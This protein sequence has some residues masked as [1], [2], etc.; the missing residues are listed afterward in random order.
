MLVSAARALRR[1]LTPRSLIFGISRFPALSYRS[2][3][4]SPN[5]RDDNWQRLTNILADDN[6]PPVQVKAMSN[7]GIELADGPLI[8]GA[9]IFLDGKIFLWDVPPMLWKG[10]AE[11]RF[12]MFEVVVPRPGAYSTD[13]TLSASG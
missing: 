3:H 6:P 2:L 9:C 11:E 12:E 4:S 1:P 10:W 8:P 5:H 7:A 13:V